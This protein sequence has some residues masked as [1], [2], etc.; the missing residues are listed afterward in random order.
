MIYSDPPVDF[1][2]IMMVSLGCSFIRNN[3]GRKA[4]VLSRENMDFLKTNQET[5]S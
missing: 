3:P 1:W 5:F 2:K 4:K